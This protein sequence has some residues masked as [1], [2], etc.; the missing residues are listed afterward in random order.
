MRTS[1]AVLVLCGV[2]ALD[3][4]SDTP[5]FEVASIK[6][7]AQE[8]PAGGPAAIVAQQPFMRLDGNRFR[9]ANM[10]AARLMLEAYGREYVHRDQIQGGPG[11]LDQ[12]RF[13]IEALAP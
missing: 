6:I 12:E 8:S 11:W 7:Q 2:V 1:V 9:A 10:T 3:A 5:T 4:Q 13:Q